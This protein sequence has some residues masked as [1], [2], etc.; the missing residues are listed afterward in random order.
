MLRPSVLHKKKESLEESLLIIIIVA[1]IVVSDHLEVVGVII[2]KVTH[3]KS[4][5]R[6]IDKLLSEKKVH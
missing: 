1:E 4:I 5:F 6:M 2:T 3:N